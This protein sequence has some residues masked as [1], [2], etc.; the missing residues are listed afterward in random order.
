LTSLCGYAGHFQGNLTYREKGKTKEKGRKKG[1]ASS[2]LFE[3]TSDGLLRLSQLFMTHN[4]GR[5]IGI[6]R[7]ASF[8]QSSKS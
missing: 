4:S 7:E 5:N 6:T 1:N 3:C 2:T 8:A